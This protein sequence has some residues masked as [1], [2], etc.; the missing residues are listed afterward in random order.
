MLQQNQPVNILIAEDDD[1]HYFLIEKILKDFHG[2]AHLHRVGDGEELMDYLLQRGPYENP[3]PTPPP[4]LVIL[5][6]NM[7][8]KDGLEALREIKTHPDLRYIPVIVMTASEMGEKKFQSYD[9]GANS[10][11]RKPIELKKWISTMEVIDHYWFDTVELPNKDG[12]IH[13]QRPA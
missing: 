7:P 3:T 10:Y 1:D 6:I 13:E 4:A 9:L 2:P 5:D 8:K 12:D 11:I